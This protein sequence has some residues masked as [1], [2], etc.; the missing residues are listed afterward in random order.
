MFTRAGSFACTHQR[1][2][3]V[4]F[5]GKKKAAPKGPQIAK[6]TA[7]QKRSSFRMPVEFDV[8]YALHGRTGRRQGRAYDLSSGGLRLATDEDLLVESVLDMDFSLPDAFLAELTIEA[9]P[10]PFAPMRA[11]AVVLSTYFMPA[12]QR[13]AYGVKFLDPDPAL[14]EELQRFVHLWQVHQLQLRQQANR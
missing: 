3:A 12:T 14:T 7:A 11:S 6:P 4:F 13:F 5:F 1:R 10:L 8:R 2:T 9:H